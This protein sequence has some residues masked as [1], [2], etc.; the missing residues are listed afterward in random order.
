M[1]NK[2]NLLAALMALTLGGVAV[3][4]AQGSSTG[5]SSQCCPSGQCAP[6]CAKCTQC[7]ANCSPDDV[8]QKVT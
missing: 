8:L 4:Q 1:R 3:A 2:F 7:D 5:S 6:C